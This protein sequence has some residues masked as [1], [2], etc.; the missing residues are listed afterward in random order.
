MIELLHNFQTLP[1]KNNKMTCQNPSTANSQLISEIIVLSRQFILARTEKGTCFT[2]N[3]LTHE[4]MLINKNEQETIRSA[5]HNMVNNS[6][7]IVSVKHRDFSSRMKCRSVSLEDLRQGRT[8]GRRLFKNFTLQYPDFVEVDD[9]NRKVV[10]KHTVD[11]CFRVWDLGTYEMLYVLRHDYLFEFKICNGVMLLMYEYLNLR[12]RALSSDNSSLNMVD[13]PNTM[14]MSIINVN[15]GKPITSFFYKQKED[16]EFEFLEQ[17]NEKLLV[18]YKDQPLEI[19]NVLTNQV[20]HI[21]NFQTP[22]A[23]IFVYE[24]E[25]FLALKQGKIVI[26]NSNGQVLSNFDNQTLFTQEPALDY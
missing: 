18:K 6:I 13:P 7:F 11:K 20:V 3:R 17:Y 15:D 26:Y 24:K 21:P 8:K 22:E 16:Q 1:A 23:F 5:F 9:L 2:F 4:T 14:P 10:T 25:I 12:N 19:K